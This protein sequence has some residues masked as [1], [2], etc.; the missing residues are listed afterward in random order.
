[1]WGLNNTGQTITDPMDTDLR[2]STH[3]PVTSDKDM[4]LTD[5][6]DVHT[7]CSSVIVAIV[8][9]GVNYNHEDLSANMWEGSVSC[10]ENGG[11][12]IPDGC[13]NHGYD[14]VEKVSSFFS[15]IPLIKK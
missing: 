12:D 4:G 5:A 15:G 2:Y 10:K 7:D 6:W 13:P 1:M 11:I 8:D 9:S 3:N 14:F